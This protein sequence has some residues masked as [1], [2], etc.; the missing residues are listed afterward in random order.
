MLKRLKTIS[1]KQQFHWRH[2]VNGSAAL[3]LKS[4]LRALLSRP[5]PFSRFHIH[6]SIWVRET[7][8]RQ[9]CSANYFHFP[10]FICFY[11][12]SIYFIIVAF[13]SNLA[14]GVCLS[15]C[16]YLMTAHTNRHTDRQT[17][18]T[19]LNYPELLLQSKLLWERFNLATRIIKVPAAAT[20]AAV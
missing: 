15:V 9:A 13:A 20:E 19:R 7:E 17:D 2:L 4:P 6:D 14:D 10:F 3:F 8:I 5:S 12:S 18:S 16:P 11:L 1:Y